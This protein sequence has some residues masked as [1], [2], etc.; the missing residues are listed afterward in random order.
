MFGANFI[1]LPARGGARQLIV[2]RG[3]GPRAPAGIDDREKMSRGLKAQTYQGPTYRRK[4][5]LAEKMKGLSAK[6]LAEKIGYLD[7]RDFPRAAVF[8]DLPRRSYGPNR[9]LR[10]KDEL[11]VVERGSVEIWH[12]GHDRLIKTLGR[13]SIFGEMALLGQAM[14]GT[15]VTM[16]GEGV[17]VALM[18]ADAARALVYSDPLAVM[19]KVGRRLAA[20]EAQ[21]QRAEF[22]LADSKVA[23][24]LLE[25][26]G[27]GS[28]VEGYSH[29]KLG[30][31]IGLYRETVTNVLNVLKADKVVALSRKRVNILDRRQLKEL[32]RL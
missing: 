11:M 24:L 13:G 5:L 18:G 30:E 32:S 10:L 31:R 1:D 27:D 28:V 14:I 25:L 22:Q 16:G 23:A 20:V 2:R 26:A 29:E 6:A 8:R 9:I 19:E 4:H 15:P 12:T 21:H 17:T 7:I 3:R